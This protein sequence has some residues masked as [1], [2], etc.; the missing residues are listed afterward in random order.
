MGFAGK[1]FRFFIFSNLFI[2]CCAAGMSWLTYHLLGLPVN[3]DALYFIFSATLCSYSFHWM[4]T[5]DWPGH[6]PRSDWQKKYPFIHLLLL[7]PAAAGT[8]WFG[9]TLIAYW[10][11]LTLVAFLT[12]LYSAPKIPHPL[13]HL[14]RR[15]ALGKTLFLT[16]V[17][18]IV[19]TLLPVVT[20]GG[21]WPDA[22]IPFLLNRFFLVYA[23]CILFDLRDLDYD[24]RHG[25]RSMITWLSP[26]GVK[27][28]FV[29]SILL[30]MISG[31]LLLAFGQDLLPVACL[32][33]PGI[34]TAFLYRRAL[35]FPADLLYYF[36]LDGLMALPAALVAIIAFAR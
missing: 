36:V 9:W 32:L 26:A 23:I 31:T 19:T 8:I 17:W 25:I 29:L 3:P 21:K 18:T 6:S 11:F 22:T 24:R 34:I 2:S 4:L 14:L 28:L 15:I 27:R 5:T 10:P 33:I 12:F 7:A 1:L 16:I 20:S 13:F 35:M 30:F